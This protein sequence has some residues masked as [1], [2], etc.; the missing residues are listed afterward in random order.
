MNK[1]VGVMVLMFLCCALVCAGGSADSYSEDGYIRAVARDFGRTLEEAEKSVASATWDWYEKKW[2]GEWT[3]ERFK[4]AVTQGVEN[5]KNGA[6]I[7]AAKAGKT[8]KKVLKALV[9]AAGDAVEAVSGWVDKN[10]E[11]YDEERK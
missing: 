6:M 10:S 7:T 8:G 4:N 9:V 1:A 11:R 2:E 5:C 3:E